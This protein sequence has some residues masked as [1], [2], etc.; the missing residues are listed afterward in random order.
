MNDENI[1][2]A[3]SFLTEEI[4]LCQSIIRHGFSLVKNYE[5]LKHQD[6]IFSLI[7]STGVER[8]LKVFIH[9]FEYES[10]STFVS[11]TSM[12]QRFGHKIEKIANHLISIGFSDT[13][14]D[15]KPLLKI[16]DDFIKN[17]AGLKL[18][19]KALSEFAN[20]ERYTFMNGVSEPDKSF[21]YISELW[22][23]YLIHVIGEKEYYDLLGSNRLDQVHNLGF[24]KLVIDL[25]QFLRSVAR[26]YIFSDTNPEFKN[27]AYSSEYSTL[28][29]D[30]LF[31][32]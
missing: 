11:L 8:Y 2:R 18:I 29:D 12:K 26:I 28:T 16:D 1:N 15:A 5:P 19:F 32:N 31:S 22:T 3:R 17:D 25:Q 23:P 10:K 21:N 13:V 4:F 6:F 14:L 24:G 9:L 20:Q 30:Q 7:L 27:I